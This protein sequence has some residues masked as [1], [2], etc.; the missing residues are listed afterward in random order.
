[1]TDP[2]PT[3]AELVDAVAG[4]LEGD[5]R[6]QVSGSTAY[7]LRVAVNALR[8]VEREL[9]AADTLAALD[10]ERSALAGAPADEAALAALVRDGA[11]AIDDPALRAYLVR[12]VRARV[13]I[14]APGYPAAAEADR[15]WGGNEPVPIE[16]GQDE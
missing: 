3:A 11:I 9:A 13:A 8:I 4:F 14:D 12:S 16:E 7:T 2:R 15:R 1:M 5:L 6:D 10:A